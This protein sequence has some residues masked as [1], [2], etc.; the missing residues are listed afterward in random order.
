MRWVGHAVC[1]EEMRNVDKIFVRKPEGK[2][3]LRTLRH[4]WEDNI[5]MDIREIRWEVMDWICQVEERDQWWAVVN[6]VFRFHKR[7]G[8]S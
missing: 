5:V 6:T 3:N 8:I 1:T 4:T 7:W 2:R